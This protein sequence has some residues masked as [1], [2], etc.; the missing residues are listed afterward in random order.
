MQN[1]LSPC[2]QICKLVE[3]ICIGC[4]RTKEE[5]TNWTKMSQEK[6]IAIMENLKGVDYGTSK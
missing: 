1:I 2:Q 6:R 5:I 3:N 4:G